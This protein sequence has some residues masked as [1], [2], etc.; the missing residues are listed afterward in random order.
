MIETGDAGRK[1]E[2]EAYMYYLLAAAQGVGG[3][4]YDSESK[5]FVGEGD[6]PMQHLAR[7]LSKAQIADAKAR[8]KAFKVL[9]GPMP[10]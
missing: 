1:D 9:H 3:L 6:S 7:R 4:P 2:V 10:K 5:R 8:M